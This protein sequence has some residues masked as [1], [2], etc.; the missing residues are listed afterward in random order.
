MQLMTKRALQIF[1][2]QK[3]TDS[4]Y[5]KIQDLVQYFMFFKLNAINTCRPTL[6]HY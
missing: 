5:E 2:K 1:I 4:T 3:T 6:F